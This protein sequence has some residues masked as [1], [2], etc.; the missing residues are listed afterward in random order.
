M[1][2]NVRGV[3]FRGLLLY[4]KDL[5]LTKI[6]AHIKFVYVR[7]QILS[8]LKNE[9]EMTIRVD[10]KYVG[11]TTLRLVLRFFPD[12]L[13]HRANMDRA[14]VVWSQGSSTFYLDDDGKIF[15]VIVDKYSEASDDNKLASFK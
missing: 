15:K 7:P 8:L 14:A 11:L 13:W 9:K 6:K 3:Q 5:H 12:Q 2:D 1:E 4:I 10:W